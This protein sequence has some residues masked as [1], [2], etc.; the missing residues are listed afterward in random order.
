MVVISFVKHGFLFQALY[1]LT[2]KGA[3]HT[4]DSSSTLLRVSP[5]PIRGYQVM[6]KLYK[7]DNTTARQ[8]MNAAEDS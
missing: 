3:F 1:V 6:I 4:S 8:E 5:I 7:D 2:Q